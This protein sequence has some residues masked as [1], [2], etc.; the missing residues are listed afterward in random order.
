ME[1]LSHSN[2][3]KKFLVFVNPHS[4]QGA[5]CLEQVEAWMKE[6]NHQIINPTFDP[7]KQDMK[8]LIHQ[9]HVDADAIIIGGGDGS[10]QHALPAL[11]KISKPLLVLP[12]GTANNLARTLKIPAEVPQA[13][14][15]LE[16]PKTKMLDVG[17]V[18]GI[19]FM[20]VVGVGLSTRVNR[21]TQSHWKR[22]FGKLA[23]VFTALKVA[24]NMDPFRIEIICDGKRHISKS[25]QVTVCNGSTYGTNLPISDDAT[26]L[27][28]QLHGLSTEVKS[29]WEGFTLIP[30]LLRGKF[31]SELPVTDFKGKEIEII[32]RRHHHVD[33]DGDIH[34]KTPVKISVKPKALLVI[35]P[36]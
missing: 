4:R 3:M 25:W 1:Q 18:N 11:L 36:A 10:V 27:D 16:A 15:L 21:L 34:T 6:Q 35:V 19:P 13:L 12:L 29:I 32:T 22:W 2:L 26:L 9:L 8:L 5:A 20:T 28:N 23:F 17:I 14:S 33:V 30:H 31:P 24:F 7:D